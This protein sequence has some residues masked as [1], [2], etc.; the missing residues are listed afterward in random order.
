MSSGKPGY[1]IL[2]VDDEESWLRNLRLHLARAGVTNTLP[3]TDPR[4]ARDIVA[5]RRIGLAIV[6]LIMPG[7]GGE[8]LL[9]QLREEWPN[10]PVII[11]SGVED[12]N[13]AVR[14]VKAGA[15]DYFV[16]TSDL[17]SLVLAIRRAEEVAVLRR[18]ADALRT[19]ILDGTIEHPEYFEDIITNDAAMRALFRYIEATAP[20][21][22]PF[23]ITG[24]TGVGKE[25]IARAVHKASEREG[26]LVSVN[27]AGLDDNVIAD[28]LFGHS[29]G[30]YTGADAPREGLIRK[31]T[32]GTLFLDEIG[33]LSVASQVKLLRLVQEREYYPL[34]ADAPVRTN[35]RIIV[36]TQQ[37]IADLSDAG[38]FRKDL[39]FRLR[40]YHVH[41]CPLRERMADLPLLLAHFVSD[42][43][44]A[45]GKTRPS[46]PHDVIGYL[47]KYSF[48]G[49]IRELR[50]M[51]Y[52]AVSVSNEP[53][54]PLW[55][56]QRRLSAVAE[57]EEAATAVAIGGA[58][59]FGEQLPTLK[60]CAALL[61]EEALR[62]ANGN[63]GV[64]AHLLGIT[65]QALNSRLRQRPSDDSPDE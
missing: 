60:D 55:P 62:R 4:A 6:D 14:C 48:P 3:C 24:E 59:V 10:L 2:L 13:T 26:P 19:R 11:L 5:S 38:K 16:K 37:S 52:D 40:T 33:D 34:G 17:E 56:F 15:F 32:G 7:M 57:I 45:L 35:A 49:N 43:A 28:T 36:A 21:P 46:I 1:E 22:E 18:Q 8:E 51:V 53:T 9:H 30:A 41:V 54:L 12:L 50:A 61:V 20:S 31:A 58:V 39:L 63:Q 64:A 23:L 65:R 47:S 42:A 25:L 27:V 29:R 44:A